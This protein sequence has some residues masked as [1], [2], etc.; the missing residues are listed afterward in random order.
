MTRI[1]LC[2][3]HMDDQFLRGGNRDL[4]G[5]GDQN[6]AAS[7][8]SYADLDW[9]AGERRGEFTLAQIAPKRTIANHHHGRR[10]ARSE[11]LA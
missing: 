3:C 11:K 5:E 4:L 2:H 7:F 6:S 1:T 10:F 8:R 9:L